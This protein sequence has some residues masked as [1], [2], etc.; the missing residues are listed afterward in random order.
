M[1]TQTDHNAYSAL[2]SDSEES[3]SSELSALLANPDIGTDRALS[4]RDFQEP[5]EAGGI[6]RSRTD[7]PQQ[8]VVD[9]ETEE[10]KSDF[11][12][13]GLPP[14]DQSPLEASGEQ[15]F[16]KVE[17]IATVPPVKSINDPASQVKINDQDSVQVRDQV[18]TGLVAVPQPPVGQRPLVSSSASFRGNGTVAEG[19]T[20]GNIADLEAVSRQRDLSADIKLPGFQPG[21]QTKPKHPVRQAPA[22]PSGC[23]GEGFLGSENG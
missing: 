10:E 15:G 23:Q 6:K 2:F 22:V 4:I 11:N 16:N 20:N 1:E 7:Q 17:P 3:E 9:Y 5:S 12:E 18:R 13:E 19:K 21:V 14:N 8:P